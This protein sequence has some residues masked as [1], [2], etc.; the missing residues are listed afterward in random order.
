MWPDKAV[1]SH[2]LSSLLSRTGSQMQNTHVVIDNLL[3]ES[4]PVV[5]YVGYPIIR[6][7]S[8]HHELSSVQNIP[9]SIATS[10]KSYS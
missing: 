5:M 6:T 8:T 7:L 1:T 3:I 9:K 2:L 4:F 10:Y